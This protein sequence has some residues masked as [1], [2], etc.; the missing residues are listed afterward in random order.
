[1]EEN[2]H[3]LAAEKTFAQLN[4]AERTAVLAAMSEEDFEQLGNI[5]R[6]A[7]RLDADLQ[8]PAGL[9]SRLLAH[10]AAQRRPGLLRRW[11]NSP[12]PV[13][14]AAAA[15]LVL[16]AMFWMFKPQYTRTVR[17]TE[18]Q[19]RVDTVYQERIRVV[20]KVRWRERIIYRAKAEKP[21][22][23]AL[24]PEL[25]EQAPMFPSPYSPAYAAPPIGTS[26][27]DAPELLEFIT[28]GEK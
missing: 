17:Q 22:P 23:L 10:A 6:T 14:K 5:L 7:P 1:M 26:L 15:L 4:E 21:G 11:A 24:A 28:R 19:Y 8:A 20:E 16:T 13:W 3:R 2:I 25:Q 18:V 27:Q 9:R 12:V